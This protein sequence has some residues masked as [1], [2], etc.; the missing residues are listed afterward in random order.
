MVGYITTKK[1]YFNQVQD[2]AKLKVLYLE[3]LRGD[4]HSTSQLFAALE[5][6]LH[7]FF[8]NRVSSIVDGEDLTQA[9]LLKIHLARAQFDLKKPLNTWVFTIA[10]NTLTDHWR[11]AE[12]EPSTPLESFD[13]DQD[14]QEALQIPDPTLPPDL[15]AQLKFDLGAALGILKPD[16]RSIVFL[17]VTQGCSMAEVA[18]ILGLTETATKVRAHRAYERLRRHLKGGAYIFILLF[19]GEALK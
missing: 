14:F 4:A 2:W 8:R 15:R 13:S 10:R 16:D 9:C 11:G 6:A 1:S 12:P 3:Y 17:C 7:G 18:E 19:F 5:K